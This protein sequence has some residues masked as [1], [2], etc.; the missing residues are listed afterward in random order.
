VNRGETVA[1][2]GESGSGKSVTAQAILGLVESPGRIVDGDIR[3][4][5]RSL[6]HGDGAARYAQSI[7]GRELGVVFQ[8]PMTSLNPLLR[9]G[10]QIGEVLVDHLDMNRKQARTRAVELLDVVGITSPERR[11]RQFPHELS[12]G[13]RQ[14]VLI[15][16]ALACEPELLIADEPTTALDVTTQAQILELLAA[17][18]QRMGLAVLLITHD[19]GIVATLCHR[20]EVMYA[21]RL[22]ER[23]GVREIFHRPGHPY[24]AGLLRSTP[25]IDVDTDRLWSIAG[26]PPDPRRPPPG[27]PFRPRCPLAVDDCL[28][29]PALAEH[30]PGR[31]VA[32]WR[33]FEILEREPA[34]ATGE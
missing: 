3:W 24:T 27:C 25:R 31:T 19:L 8:D 28:E 17:I 11:V 5:G 12:G 1:L 30:E 34:E 16:M 32:C 26:T 6:L 23:A 22:M 9:V 29:M 20:V 14:R 15:A 7:R 4:K 10:T 21:G 33:P 13:M 2:V 18:Q